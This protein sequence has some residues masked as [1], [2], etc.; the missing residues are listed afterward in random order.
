VVGAADA[1]GTSA[2]AAVPVVPN[3]GADD[4]ALAREVAHRVEAGW[5]DRSWSWRLPGHELADRIGLVPPRRIAPRS[6]L[7][8]R[9]LA[10]AGYLRSILG[11]AWLGPV[12]AAVVLAGWALADVDARPV[13]PATGLVIAVILLA[14]VDALAGAL[15]VTVFWLGVLLTGGVGDARLPDAAGSIA[16]LLVLG[17]L[18]MALPLI[19][20]ATRPFRRRLAKLDAAEKQRVYA[21]DRIADG[22]I[23]AALVGWVAYKLTQALEPFAG[24]ELPIADHALAIGIT[25]AGGVVLRIVLEEVAEHGYPLRLH[26]VEVPGSLPDPTRA[27]QVG[28]AL[29]RTA[30]LGLMAYVF[31]GSCWQLWVG[32]AMVGVWQVASAYKDTLPRSARL[33]KILPRGIT[34]ILV[35]MLVC[36]VVAALATDGRIGLHQVRD[37]FVI[38]AVPSSLLAGISLFAVSPK[39]VRWN[40]PGQL[41]GVAVYVAIVVLVLVG[42]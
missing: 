16:V 11:L 26:Q 19:G 40:W 23:A 10:D 29:L 18:W 17:L 14:C 5:G 1:A 42:W 32:M 31:L 4:N 37:C 24:L 39:P 21:W 34:K 13:P 41:A 36:T 27:S 25:T 22:A 35:M 9:L 38:M 15:A 3:A 6:P 2:A 33:G 8:G 28:G 20:S 7:A 30:M 12:I